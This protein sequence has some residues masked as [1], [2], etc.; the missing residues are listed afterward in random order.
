MAHLTSEEG[1]YPGSQAQT[2]APSPRLR[3]KGEYL[4]SVLQ[5]CNIHLLTLQMNSKVSSDYKAISDYKSVFLSHSYPQLNICAICEAKI[6]SSMFFLIIKDLQIK[7]AIGRRF[8]YKYSH[9]TI[10]PA[11]ASDF[12]ALQKIMHFSWRSKLDANGGQPK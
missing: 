4:C 7:Q 6:L 5:W 11:L 9:P 10:R 12:F 3:L 2:S 1:E 8:M